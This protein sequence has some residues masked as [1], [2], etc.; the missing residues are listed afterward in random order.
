MYSEYI[1][2]RKKDASKRAEKLAKQKDFVSFQVFPG[3][4]Y[5]SMFDRISERAK[6]A[7]NSRPEYEKLGEIVFLDTPMK[8]TF[9]K[10]CFRTFFDTYGWKFAD[11]YGFPEMKS[12]TDKEKKLNL[13]MTGRIKAGSEFV[14]PLSI[15]SKVYDTTQE[16][17]KFR[18]IKVKPID[19][20]IIQFTGKGE[21]I[22]KLMRAVLVRETYIPEGSDGRRRFS[23]DHFGSANSLTDFQIRFIDRLSSWKKEGGTEWPKPKDLLEAI[24]FFKTPQFSQMTE[25]FS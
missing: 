16:M 17:Y 7:G 11:A 9:L 1:S 13:L 18:E 15:L 6:F 24:S 4:T 19:E 21:R 25:A 14:F 10:E 12:I 20:E 2:S 5:E 22:K 23:K 3:D 8:R